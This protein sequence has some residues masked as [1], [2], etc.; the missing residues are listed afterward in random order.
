[1]NR[2]KRLDIQALRAIAV[3][4]VVLYHLW[5]NRLT[6]G[7]MGVDIFFVI[8]GY[9]MTVT[10]MRDLQPV[11]KAKNK[12]KATGSFLSAF[13][14]R[15]IKRLIPAASAVLLATL[16]L[17]IATGNLSLIVQTAK[18]IMTSALFV[19][20]WQLANE[21]VDYLANT[22][23]TAVQHFWSL[24]LEEQFYLIWPLLLLSL[25]LV[26]SNLFI[27]YKR[28][29][30]AS[31][32]IIPLA[33]LIAGFFAYGYHLTQTNP[34]LAYFVT[35]ARVW[36]L[37]LG[38]AIAFLPALKNYDLRLLLPWV[39]SAM[40]AYALYKW[41]GANF[42]G[43]H[44]AVPTIGTALIIYAGT[45]APD[46]KWSFENVLRFKPV[47]WLGNLSYSLYLWHWPLIILLPILLFID[48]DAHPQSLLIKLGVL[49]LSLVAALLSYRYI[50]QT[51]QHIK[52]KKRYVY[53]GFVTI[54]VLVA[55]L[56]YF[57]SWRAERTLQ[58]ST[59]EV[60][61]SVLSGSDPCLGAQ[62]IINKCD[63]SFGVIRSDYSQIAFNDK[64]D[65]L[66]NGGKVCPALDGRKNNDEL[67]TFC[68][69]GDLES[70]REITVW[71]DSHA[72]HWIN[73]MDKI[74]RKN[75]IKI[76]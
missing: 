21:S 9:L 47:Q 62:S 40:I 51:T 73:P 23:P 76:F 45:L 59:D 60:R 28:K 6:G 5:P 19:Q 17:V 39:G 18:Q 32:A 49:A 15:R 8:S 69:V 57:T 20:N 58:A 4:S 26:F 74:G 1:M 22:N 66:L 36:E 7:F 2:G 50:E 75:N 44:A 33:L 61:A 71:G 42:P 35:P 27:T 14:A 30:V 55:G 16:G 13:Y 38:G 24:S 37:L 29:E 10:I 68:Q 52:L 46:S 53:A 12:L 65:Q 54:T 64:Y 31:L 72:Q 25:L 41:D 34:S 48:I 70:K 3:L 67:T 63:E 43:W 11:L 56:A